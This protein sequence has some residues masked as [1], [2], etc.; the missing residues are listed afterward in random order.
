MNLYD[1]LHDSMARRIYVMQQNHTAYAKVEYVVWLAL[2]TYFLTPGED[3]L[4]RDDAEKLFESLR[5]YFDQVEQMS[6]IPGR[7]HRQSP[8]DRLLMEAEKGRRREMFEA[9]GTALT[10]RKGERR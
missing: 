7:V 4:N 9:S 2:Q 10:G 1:D 3:R 6:P 8:Y 5:P